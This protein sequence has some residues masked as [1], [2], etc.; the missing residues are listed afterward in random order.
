MKNGFIKVAAASP[1]LRVAGVSYNRE[2]C[3][4]TARLAAERGVK[5]LV[6]PEL[7][8][9]GATAGDLFFHKNLLLCAER[10]LEAYIEET[11]ELDLISFV[12][13]PA[14]ISGRVYNAV[15]AVCRGALLALVPAVFSDSRYFAPSPEENI[16]VSFAGF[17]TLLG[18]DIILSCETLPEL[19]VA[20][21]VGDDAK[22]A[23]SPSRAHAAA[24]ATLIV[25][26]AADM[27]TVGLAERLSGF[28]KNESRTLSCAYILAEAGK[29]ES[30]TDGVYAGRSVIAECGDVLAEARA[31]EDGIITAVIDAERAQLSRVRRP[32][33]EESDCYDYISFAL[34]GCETEIENPPSRLPF[35]PEDGAEMKKRAEEILAIQSHAL[36]GRITRSHSSGAVIGV[37]GGLDSTLALLVAVRA[38]DILGISRK[39]ITAVTMPCFGTTARTKGNAEKLAEALGVTLKCIDIKASVTQHFEDIGHSADNFN[40]VYENAQARER[41]QVLMD[42]ANAVGALVVGTGDLSELALGWATYNGD[43]MSMYGVNAGVPKTLMRYLVS[44]CADISEENGDTASAQVLR[45]V[46]LTPVSPEL[47]PPKDGEIAQCTEGIVGPYELH[48]FFLYYTVRRGFTPEKILRIAEAAFRGVYEREVIAGWLKV[49]VRRFFAQQFKR[50][51]LPDGPKIGS[52]GLSPRGDF[53]MPSDAVCDGWLES[54]K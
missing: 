20:V 2:E 10:E 33:F 37:S 6:F 31:F 50:S 25:N 44:Y 17:D 5:L 19:S 3:V 24:G 53:K 32:G 15:A 30:G 21:C 42:I 4:R 46:L 28:V 54:I 18:T 52:V 22:A 29:G 13:L 7:S 1:A 23:F 27:E 39:N 43:H 11:A 41:T 38:A 40:V 47:L 14:L 9:T 48:D 36:A 49:F 34:D 12:G 8:L 16:E 26:P 35:V 45:D 51:C